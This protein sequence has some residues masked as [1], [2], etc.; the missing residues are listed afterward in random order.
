MPGG[1]CIF[2]ETPMS[3]D[4]KPHPLAERRVVYAM[5][6]MDAVGI[7]RDE[8]YRMTDAGDL[9]MDIYY[10]PGSSGA[11]P[12]PAVLFL[13]GFPDVGAERMFGAKFKDMGS[14]VSWARLAAVSGIAAITYANSD[15]AD[16]DDV[17]RHIHQKGAS[18]GID[19]ARLGVWS[20]SG[21]APNALA[22]LMRHGRAGLRC[23]ALAY[24][25]TLDFGE[26]TRVAAAAKQFGFV[27]PARAASMHSLPRELPLLV[28]RAGR[29]DMPGLNEALDRFVVEA[30]ALNLPLTL[31]NQP[32][33]PHAFDLFDE[34]T[35]S[36]QVVRQILAF[37]QCH[38][39][40]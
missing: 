38:L 19:S 30:L 29:D 39:L 8:R 10:P 36:R 27:T 9:T 20:C 15:P 28:A 6:G 22:V 35:A 14:F 24:P 13:T 2:R 16:V 25:Y 5:P 4:R 26:S 11:E 23:A 7:R 21:H 3:D 31:V 18:L 40:S 37:L 32:D 17:L 1:F 12:V 34:G 33:A